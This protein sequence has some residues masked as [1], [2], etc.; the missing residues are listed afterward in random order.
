MPDV[1]VY[2]VPV[3]YVMMVYCYRL[4]PM[5]V[6]G[7]V[8]L[9]SLAS[10]WRWQELSALIEVPHVVEDD[11]STLSLRYVALKYLCLIVVCRCS[12]LVSSLRDV[13]GYLFA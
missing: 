2:L 8:P 11:R 5:S 13:V 1:L 6:E 3:S 12:F 9:E 10:E 4:F 7:V